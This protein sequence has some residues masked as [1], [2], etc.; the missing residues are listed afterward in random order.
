MA[1]TL[2]AA[3]VASTVQAKE[4]NQNLV[5]V[6]S[7]Y[8]L[9]AALVVN[10]V[11]QMVK[12][13]LGAQIVN[14]LLATDDIDSGGSPAIVLA[15]GDGTTADR[16]IKGSAIG[17]TG[18]VAKLGDGVTAATAA[19]SLGYVYTADDTIDVKVTTAPATGTTTGT[20]TLIVTYHNDI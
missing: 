11:I 15:V 10:D 3:K 19:D 20:I 6:V 8:E 16:Y 13:P 5:A 17:Q 18:G 14:V 12:V 1:S 4:T 7:T 2:T 9:A